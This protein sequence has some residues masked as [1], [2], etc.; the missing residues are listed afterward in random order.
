MIV[1]YSVPN[2]IRTYT[3][4]DCNKTVN[5]LIWKSISKYVNGSE[6]KCEK[7]WEKFEHNLENS[8]SRKLNF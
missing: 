4:N 6:Y 2:N 5:C 8:I 1:N 3:C 7:C